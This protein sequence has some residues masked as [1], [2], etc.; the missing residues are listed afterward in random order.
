MGFLNETLVCYPIHSDPSH[1]ACCG[2]GMYPPCGSFPASGK[3]GKSPSPTTN[4][5]VGKNGKSRSLVSTT[6][7]CGNANGNPLAPNANPPCCGFE[8][9]APCTCDICTGE[10]CC[11]VPFFPQ[12]PSVLSGKSGKGYGNYTYTG[13][14]GCFESGDELGIMEQLSAEVDEAINESFSVPLDPDEKDF[15]FDFDV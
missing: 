11:G 3:S 1:P 12:C 5:T 10:G 4:T 9:Y 6:P 14:L 2:F 13:D 7:T 8:Y 15:S